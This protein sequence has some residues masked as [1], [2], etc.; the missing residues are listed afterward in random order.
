MVVV[1]PSE[2][3]VEVV[4]GPLDTAV[5][6]V[7]GPLETAVVVVTAPLETAVVVVTAQ[8]VTS[9]DELELDPNVDVVVP[10]SAVDVLTTVGGTYTGSSF[11]GGS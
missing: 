8:L 2:T 3:T 6:V 11:T 1:V 9:D 4:T 10:V 5:E 7:T